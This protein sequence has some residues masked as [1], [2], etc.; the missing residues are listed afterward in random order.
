MRAVLQRVRKAEVSVA[1]ETIGAIG[2]GLCVFLGVGKEDTQKDG[3]YLADKIINLRIFPDKEDKMNLSLID[4]QGEILVVSQFTLY[5]DCRKGRR[6]GFSD[7]A[8]PDRGKELYESFVLYLKEKGIL[9]ATGIFQAEMLVS[10]ENDGPVT[11]L[12]DSQKNF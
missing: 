5:G 3:E 9:V 7:A 4:I 12:L 1:G 11:I 10:I 6:P 2:Q 8:K